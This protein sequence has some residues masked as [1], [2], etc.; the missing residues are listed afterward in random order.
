MTLD[1][2]TLWLLSH[3][4]GVF[5]W[6]EGFRVMDLDQVNVWAR[7]WR[8]RNPEKVRQINARAWDKRKDEV[9]ARRREARK[10]KRKAA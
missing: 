9:N 2:E 4:S 7:E 6:S 8:A 3:A 1:D 5:L 10:A